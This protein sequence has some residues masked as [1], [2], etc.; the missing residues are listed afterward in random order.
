MNLSWLSFY[1]LILALWVGGIAAVTFIITPAIFRSF[2]RDQAGQIVGKLFPGYFLYNL[3]LAALALVLFF[4][5]AGDE[6]SP[7]AR[8]SLF[9][10]TL[11]LFINAYVVF[12]LHPDTVRVKQ[13][14]SSFEQEPSDSAARKQFKKL[15]A[16][17]ASLNLLLLAAGIVLL[18]MSPALKK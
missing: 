12:K 15:H 11:A 3:I 7:A 14:I 10:S 9:L 18:L 4:L 8:L 1:N 17:S 13:Q 5:V 6:T 2:G 16:V